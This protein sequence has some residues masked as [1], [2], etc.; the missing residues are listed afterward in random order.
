MR[1]KY[2]PPRRALPLAAT[3]PMI[4]TLLVLTFGAGVSLAADYQDNQKN[5][6]EGNGT[7]EPTKGCPEWG[8][9]VTTL[10]PAP[11]NVALGAE[12][13]EQLTTGHD[14][15]AIDAGAL[16]S[17]TTGSTNIAIG[18]A[19]L[20]RNTKGNSNIASGWE[21]LHENTTG[22]SNSAADLVVPDGN[23]QSVHLTPHWNF[24]APS[25]PAYS[26]TNAVYSLTIQGDQ[27]GYGNDTIT[28]D[29]RIK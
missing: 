12:M 25:N 9:H 3:A 22:G 1:R 10:P 7:F 11:D 21:A 19:A 4:A 2:H 15:V 20:D 18:V 17:N 14:N 5:V 6:C 24:S 26:F 27:P 29:A 23:S 16:A 13:M 8:K 28:I